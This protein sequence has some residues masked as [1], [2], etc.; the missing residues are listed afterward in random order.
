MGSLALLRAQALEADGQVRIPEGLH[1][2]CTAYMCSCWCCFPSP[3]AFAAIHSRA[4]LLLL[5]LLLLPSYRRWAQ[6]WPCTSRLWRSQ[7]S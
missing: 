4:L 3:L 2:W 5:P 1:W 7:T 6:P